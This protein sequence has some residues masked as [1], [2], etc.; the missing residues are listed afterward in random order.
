MRAPSQKEKKKLRRKPVERKDVSRSVG[1]IGG[2]KGSRKDPKKAK[3]DKQ[4]KTSEQKT[5]GNQENNA[6]EDSD[7]DLSD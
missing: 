3:T 5:K 2:G 4:A 6:T 7:D 1:S